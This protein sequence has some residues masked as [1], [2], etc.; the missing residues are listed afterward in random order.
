M[1]V[2]KNYPLG[3]HARAPL[4]AAAAECAGEQGSF[5]AMHDLLFERMDDWSKATDS[6]SAMLA[7]AATL[8][9]NGQRFRACLAGRNAMERV[10]RDIYDGQAVNVRTLPLF[11]LL[12]S[13]RGH[14]LTG[15]RSADDFA[16][17][18]QQ[19]LDRANAERTSAG[20]AAR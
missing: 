9:L 6:D 8:E 18:L 7:L 10:L 2:V 5:F 3:I 12:H 11:I 20:L 16:A 15:A 14:V 4:A 17:T 19:Q 1:W 13:G